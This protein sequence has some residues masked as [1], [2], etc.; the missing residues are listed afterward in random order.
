MTSAGSI[1]I[2][3]GVR[4]LRLIGDQ[5]Q[6]VFSWIFIEKHSEGPPAG[7]VTPEREPFVCVSRAEIAFALTCRTPTAASRLPA[8]E[9][10]GHRE[11]STRHPQS[12]GP[13]WER[14]SRGGAGPPNLTAS[15]GF[16]GMEPEPPNSPTAASIH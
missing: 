14:C 5:L 16:L 15:P 9:S 3:P 10:P 1:H 11:Q 4:T 13:A 6:S 12:P 8:R 7:R 2:K